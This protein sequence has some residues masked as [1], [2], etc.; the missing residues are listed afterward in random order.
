[1]YST[2]QELVN[3]SFEKNKNKLAIEVDSRTL[4]YDDVNR[5]TDAI[6]INFFKSEKPFSR[7]ALI[8]ENQ[9]NYIFA[10]IAILKARCVFVPIDKKYPKKRINH[11][12]NNTGIDMVLFDFN[13][14]E[15]NMNLKPPKNIKGYYCD[16]KDYL[17]SNNSYRINY[18]YNINDPIYL[19]FTSGTTSTPKAILGKNISLTHFIEWEIGLIQNNR[20]RVAQITSP[21]FD[22]YL[23]DVFVP[24]CLGGTICIPKN[25]NY[26]IN[27][28]SLVRWIE[29]K[30]ISLIHCTPTLFNAFVSS[31]S[32]CFIESLEYVFLAG[33]KTSINTLSKWFELYSDNAQIINL[34]GPTETTL[35]KM[36][37]V[38]CK[39][40]IEFG[41]IPL[42]KPI[43][44]TEILILKPDGTECEPN[45][46][47]EIAIVTPYVSHGYENNKQL[48]STIFIMN[49]KGYLY[50]TGDIGV[51]NNKG[52]VFYRGRLDR[53]VKIAGIR[54][55]L[56]EV[57]NIILKYIGITQCK[58]IIDDFKNHLIAYYS[59][60]KVENI[61]ELQEFVREHIF[62]IA[63]PKEFVYLDKVSVNINGKNILDMVYK[64]NIDD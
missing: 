21:S 62:D 57:E 31:P 3:K 18:N 20:C 33:E 42:G 19:Y 41:E 44:D 58:V 39:Q 15:K 36:F 37:H 47:G 16:Y 30:K 45:E 56:D 51:K 11:I 59:G 28:G 8:F 4:I 35:A 34:Y 10:I 46:K 40:D 5:I 63:V 64:E 25:N 7:I 50:K 6:A 61:I 14:H 52:L 13:Q 38:I 55:E 26:L 54:I 53:Q 17:N 2:I 9:A 60:Q 12:L 49:K 24:L 43:N 27:I 48:N 1:M 23:R 22:P 29:K 32:F